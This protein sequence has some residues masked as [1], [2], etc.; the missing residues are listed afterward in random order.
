MLDG[1]NVLLLRWSENKLPIHEMFTGLE[2]ENELKLREI[3]L[4]SQIEKES[5][6]L[7]KDLNTLNLSLWDNFLINELNIHIM[8]CNCVYDVIELRK[9]KNIFFHLNDSRIQILDVWGNISHKENGW[10]EI[11]LSDIANLILTL[12]I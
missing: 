5:F 9:W 6:Q 11:H 1:W 4:L 8:A 3:M 2:I 10:D 12:L 7:Y